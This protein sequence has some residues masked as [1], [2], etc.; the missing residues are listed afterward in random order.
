M[1]QLEHLSAFAI[2][3]LSAYNKYTQSAPKCN[4]PSRENCS[5]IALFEQR[6]RRSIV[7]PL[8]LALIVG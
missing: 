7:I 6:T 2:T 5:P 1:N 4:C 3:F 8:A